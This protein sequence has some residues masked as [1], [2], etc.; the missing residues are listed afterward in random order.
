M[1]VD[2]L[3]DQIEGVMTVPC[4]KAKKYKWCA[5]HKTVYTDKS[6]LKYCIFHAPEKKVKT[7]EEFNKHV[8][9]RIQ[10]A[11]ENIEICDL[12]GTIFPWKITFNQFNKDNPLPDIN[13]S[14]S[15]FN[16]NAGFF[17]TICNGDITFFKSI[18]NGEISFWNSTFRERA[19]F[20]D[21]TFNGN[22]IFGYSTFNRDVNFDRATFKK[23]ANFGNSTFN[24]NAV[25][26]YT[27]F[28]DPIFWYSTFNGNADFRKSTFDMYAK[29][30]NSTFKENADFRKTT[31]NGDA[32]FNNSTFEK[33]VNFDNST[34]K[35]SAKFYNS[36][37]NGDTFFNG[38]I[39]DGDTSFYYSTFNKDAAFDDLTFNGEAD[40]DGSAFKENAFFLNTYFNWAFFKWCKIEKAAY[41]ENID[42]SNVSF[43]DFNP[44]NMNFQGCTWPQKNYKGNR[45]LQ[46]LFKRNIVYDESVLNRDNNTYEKVEHIYRKLKHKCKKEHNEPETSSWHYGEKEMFRKKLW[47]RRWIP[48]SISN[49]YWAFSGYGERPVRAG[50]VL[51]A[52][53][54]ILSFLMSISGLHLSETTVN[55]DFKTIEGVI[56]SLDGQR[57]F[58]LIVTCMQHILFVNAPN[59]TPATHLGAFFMLLFTRVMFPIQVVLLI[60]ALRNKLRR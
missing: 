44:N 46:K 5:K 16:G 27:I 10:R 25:F 14:D 26:G 52:M 51:L 12:R 34:F 20:A 50:L 2:R 15:I 40:F 45:W 36:I 37:F 9:R 6:G 33:F 19:Y 42:L 59:F 30:W 35:G 21:S 41:F 47:W 58:H 13:F 55:I 60:L 23:Q 4:C 53:M 43:L 56:W 11:S 39:I 54:G 32:N 7:H 57:F 31:F 28:N 24:E 18:F 17:S 1:V 22:A 38:S 29:F 3:G 48:F 49:L 8:Y